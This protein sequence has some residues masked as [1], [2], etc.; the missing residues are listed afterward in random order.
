M[1]E[2]T[3]KW[4][5]NTLAKKSIQSNE[6]IKCENGTYLYIIGFGTLTSSAK[7]TYNYQIKDSNNVVLS[8][9]VN[10]YLD[11]L[12]TIV[13]GTSPKTKESKESKKESAKSN[14]NLVSEYLRLEAN[15]EKAIIAFNDFQTLHNVT[16]LQDV[17][18]L[19]ETQ[20]NAKRKAHQDARR[21]ELSMLKRLQALRKWAKDTKRIALLQSL[22]DLM[23]NL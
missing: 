3:T 15:L 22:S 9:G 1:L 5:T 10:A 14:K 21:N 18:A 19:Q 17:Q 20:R 23:L 7:N 13:K 4:V 11:K 16:S 6:G 8:E 2:L 12:T